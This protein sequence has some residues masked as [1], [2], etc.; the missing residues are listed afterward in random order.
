LRLKLQYDTPLVKYFTIFADLITELL[1]A[2]A[3]LKKE[4]DKM[5]HL[6]LN[7]LT[8][9]DVIITTIETISEDNLTLTFVKTRLLDHEVKQKP[10]ALVQV[11][12][13]QHV[14]RYTIF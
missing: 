1:A 4:T 13:A 6:L 11:H 8:S 12:Q 5:S 10:G 9:Y 3:N 7:P 14:N 2:N